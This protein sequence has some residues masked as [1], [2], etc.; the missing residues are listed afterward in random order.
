M[1]AGT[2]EMGLKTHHLAIYTKVSFNHVV[3]RS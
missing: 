3:L 2:F 1:L